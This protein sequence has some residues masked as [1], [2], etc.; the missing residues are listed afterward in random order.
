MVLFICIAKA[1]I[2]TGFHCSHLHSCV[3]ALLVKESKDAG[4]IRTDVQRYGAFKP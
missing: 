1:H 2:L 3:L 4:Q